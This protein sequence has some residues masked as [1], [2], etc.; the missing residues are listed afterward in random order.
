MRITLGAGG[1][2]ARGALLR[3]GM[4][5]LLPLLAF[6]VLN[7][8]FS[9]WPL[10]G[11]SR[12]AILLGTA[13]WSCLL[14][15]GLPRLAAPLSRALR[16]REAWVLGAFSLG[17]FALQVVLALHLRHLPITDAEQCVS[18]ASLLADTGTFATSAR[19]SLYFSRYPFNLGFVYALSGLYRLGNLLGL[20]DRYALTVIASAVFFQAGLLCAARLARRHGGAG[21]QARFLLLCALS[22]PLLPACAEL[23]TDVFALAF[24]PMILLC[25][26]GAQEAGN[27]RGR[28]GFALGFAALT[29]LGA[30]IRATVAIASLACLIEA[31]LT[32]PRRFA[33]LL[34]LC[35]AIGLP[36]H[37]AIEREN[38]RHLT[39][40]AL[41]QNR[42]PALHWIAMGLPIH[43]DEGY[44]QYGYGGWLIFSTS[45]EDPQARE[46]ALAEK[47][48][49]RIY[50]LRYPNRMLNLL[51]RKNLASFGDGTYGLGALFEG[52]EHEVNS[53]IKQ[54]LFLRGR[55]F[56]AYRQLC[57]SLL[58]AQLLLCGAGLW[59]GLRRARG[60]ALAIAL[61]GA[62]GYLFAWE[63]M[64]RYFFMFVPLMLCLGALYAREEA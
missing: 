53:R 48:K 37:A 36:G 28:A 62:Y 60:A 54:V 1:M 11:R 50:Y 38:E 41:E 17:F 34:A 64:A 56:A 8:G 31:L 27:R 51:S 30:S 20:S 47:V 42:L 19:S 6:T 14:F 32:H 49:D 2:R 4:V 26:R 12:L 40:E 29:F 15:F 18:A 5:T 61:T 43:P 22:V 10:Y 7:V 39:R 57:T 21:A 59:Q 13:L 24:P 63:T 33:L 3:L 23:Y 58:M 55:Y 25:A 35:L 45:F 16:R 44:G 52:D 9:P 46:A